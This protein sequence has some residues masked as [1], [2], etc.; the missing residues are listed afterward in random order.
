[1]IRS[2]LVCLAML[3]FGASPASA[4]GPIGHRTAARIAE[5]NISGHTRAQV[6]AIL[7]RQTLA[8]A[9]TVPDE[10]RNNPDPFW[11]HATP[12]HRVA[13]PR[14]ATTAQIVHP[15][16]GDAITALERFTAI[17]R[18][19]AAP[20]LDRQR[21]LQFV[22]H[23]VADVHLPV[24]VGDPV[25]GGGGVPV[26]WF[27]EERDLHWVWDEGMVD[28]LML[29]SDEYAARLV[30]RT[31]PEEVMALWD[32]RPATWIDESAALRDRL[33]PESAVQLSD[34]CGGDH[35]GV[36]CS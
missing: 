3:A 25:H 20:A 9:A 4:W 18:D 15:P 33:T 29:S 32:P 12:W 7:G 10:Q 28:K 6:A 22:V 31:G 5:A 35:G 17:L 24:H 14:G 26:R 16:E 11:Q 19:P 1:M 36:L 8:E 2:L 27:G 21:A 23:I 30:H 34:L 13:L